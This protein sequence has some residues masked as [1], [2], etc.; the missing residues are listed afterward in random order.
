MREQ[1]YLAGGEVLEQRALWNEGVDLRGETNGIAE[2][3]KARKL[4]GAVRHPERHYAESCRR[5]RLFPT[6][7][8]TFGEARQHLGGVGPPEAGVGDAL[9]ESQRLSR[10]Q[11][12]APPP[13]GGLHH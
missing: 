3:F 1:A 12:L 9:A 2:V 11:G 4:V 8:Y 10:P 6:F 5:A 13:P 7:P